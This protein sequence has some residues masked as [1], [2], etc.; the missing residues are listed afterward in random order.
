MTK[1][2]WAQRSGHNPKPT[3]TGTDSDGTLRINRVW[4]T[5]SLPI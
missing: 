2:T 3:L 1:L 4:L 5:T